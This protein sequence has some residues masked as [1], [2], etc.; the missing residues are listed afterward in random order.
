ML[1]GTNALLTRLSMGVSDVA[2]IDFG[3]THFFVLILFKLMRIP[4][5]PVLHNSSASLNLPR[6]AGTLLK[7]SNLFNGFGS[8]DGGMHMIIRG[9]GKEGMK[10]ERRWFIVAKDGDGPQIPCVPAILVTRALARGE[11]MARGAY[12]GVGLVGLEDYAREL[13]GY[14]IAMQSF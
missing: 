14:R 11:E 8:A 5:I 3:T 1:C 12:A 9:R 4:V 10:H 2:F 6:H 13:R 7:A